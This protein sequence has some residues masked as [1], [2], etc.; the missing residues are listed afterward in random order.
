LQLVRDPQEWFGFVSAML[1]GVLN[2]HDSQ[3]RDRLHAA[4]AP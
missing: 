4:N 3:L 2:R 1:F